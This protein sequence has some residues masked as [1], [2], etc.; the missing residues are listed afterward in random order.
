MLCRG[1]FG[2]AS[3]LKFHPSFPEAD[4]YVGVLENPPEHGIGDD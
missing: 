3:A 1:R 4:G 2:C